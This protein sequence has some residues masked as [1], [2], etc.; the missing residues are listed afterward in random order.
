MYRYVCDFGLP[1]YSEAERKFATEIRQTLNKDDLRNARL[2]IARTGGTAGREWVQ[3]LGDKVL[4]DQVAPY[5]AS[6]ELLYGSTD[7]GD[8]S[9]VAPTAQCFS[10]CFAFALRCTPGNWWHRVALRSPTKA[11]A[12]PAR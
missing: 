10:P 5:V 4:M 3:N 6:E 11:C 7:V 2:N 8:V 12:W 9:W 1:E